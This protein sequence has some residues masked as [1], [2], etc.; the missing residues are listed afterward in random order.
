MV[1]VPER[2][3]TLFT[4]LLVRPPVT[5][6]ISIS[7]FF[8]F[9]YLMLLQSYRK[10]NYYVQH[11]SIGRP[12][13]ELYVETFFTFNVDNMAHFILRLCSDFNSS[14]LVL[15]CAFTAGL[16]EVPWERAPLIVEETGGLRSTVR[17]GG[18]G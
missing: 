2:R 17:R 5:T 4:Y 12:F 8:F 14:C 3:G 16:T 9:C 1:L 6:Q 18:G 13:S 7:P 11:C 10:A 15:Y